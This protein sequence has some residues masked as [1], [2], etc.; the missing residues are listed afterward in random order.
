[1]ID[2]ACGSGHF[3]L[4]SF[5]RLVE[6]WRKKEPGTKVSVLVQRALDSVH[7][8]DLNP[9]AI[10]IARFRLLLAALKECGVIRL[11]DA[12]GFEIHLACG[13]SLLHG[14]PGGDQPTLG[15][16]SID[17]VYQPEDREATRADC[18]GPSRITRWSQTRRI[19]RPRIGAEPGL[20]RPICHLPPDSTR[21][22]CRSW[23]GSSRSRWKAGSRGRSRQTAS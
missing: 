11:S 12:P 19:S 20:S 3:L 10:A 5:A 17:H 14:S 9:Y 15:W 7:G 21:W 18:S 4:G 1:M 6:R 16:S 8:V 23:N 22:L 2:P 13:D